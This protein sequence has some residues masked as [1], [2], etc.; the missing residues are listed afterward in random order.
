MANHK[1]VNTRNIPSQ[2]TVTRSLAQKL[3]FVYA[4]WKNIWCFKDLFLL[5]KET[6]IKS[7]LITTIKSWLI[8]QPTSDSAAGFPISHFY[9]A[10]LPALELNEQ[11]LHNV[12]QVFNTLSN[13]LISFFVII[14]VVLRSGQAHPDHPPPH[15]KARTEPTART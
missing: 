7:W 9:L 12:W 3:I 15:R 10:T 13:D 11:R 1:Q 8:V 6:V 2:W 5:L 14:A 4:L